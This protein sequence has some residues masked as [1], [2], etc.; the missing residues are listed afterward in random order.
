LE[1]G[2]RA[3]VQSLAR[4]RGVGF[5]S[6]VQAEATLPNR[7]ANLVTLILVNLTENAV[8][9]TPTGKTV[10]LAFRR[11]ESRLVF[12]VR[13]EGVGFPADTPLFMPCRSTKEGGTGIGLALCK[14]LANHL[15]AELEL[16]TSTNAGC[17]FALSLV[18]PLGPERSPLPE[19]N[20]VA[21]Q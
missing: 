12:E 16:A 14:Q 17:V 7:V 10:S 1:S 15:G 18:D 4:A 19:K 9:A 21:E 5:T 6:V 13:D 2:I 20:Q 3:R 8:H 11:V